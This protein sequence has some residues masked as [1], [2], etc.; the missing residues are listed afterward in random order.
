MALQMMMCPDCATPEL[1]R[2]ANYD[3][4]HEKEV[5]AME[6]NT[7][8]D[9]TISSKIAALRA[10]GPAHYAVQRL[11]RETCNSI[12]ETEVAVASAMRD[13]ASGEAHLVTLRATKDELEDHAAHNGWTLE[14]ATE[15]K[16][17]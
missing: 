12:G 2:A 6:Y 3:C 7:T 5:F 13:V 17:S 8:S 14:V 4:G 10:L 9:G 15:G 11:W 16:S 1:C